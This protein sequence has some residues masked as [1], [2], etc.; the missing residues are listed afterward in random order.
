L[1]EN[2]NQI[3]T[4]IN[5]LPEPKY[6]D[7]EVEKLY[8]KI[9]SLRKSI[10]EPQVIPEIKYYDDEI[11]ILKKDISSLFEKVT[12]IKIPDN[13]KYN[14]KLEKF[15]DEFQQKNTVLNEKIKYLEE[16]FEYFNEPQEEVLEESII[17]EPPETKNEDPLTP[18]TQNFVTFKQLQEHYRTFL[19][20]IQQQLSTLG[21]GGETQ[22]KYLDDIVGIATNAGAYDKRYLQYNHSLRKFE[23]TPVELK[24]KNLEDI[25]GIATNPIAYDGK[26]LKYNYNTDNFEFSTIIGEDGEFEGVLKDLFDVDSTNLTNG[27]IMIYDQNR[28][29]FVFVSPQ[30]IGINNDFNIDPAIDDYGTYN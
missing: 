7:S 18:L 5:E 27:S 24:V 13:R 10:P 12:A 4:T 25:V 17:T 3:K 15:Y 22:L 2:I 14:E 8:E 21:G 6:Y 1:I 11:E 20:R 26:Y 16:I 30:S 28:D 23:F 19:S 9:E 29:K